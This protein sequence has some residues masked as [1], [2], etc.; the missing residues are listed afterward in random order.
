M[1]PITWD[2]LDPFVNAIRQVLENHD[3]YDERVLTA[4]EIKEMIEGP[5]ASIN[6]ALE[7]LIH[8][9]SIHSIEINGE[10]VYSL[11][12]FVRASGD[13]MVP[14]R[15]Q[16][17]LQLRSATTG[18]ELGEVRLTGDSEPESTGMTI[19]EV[20]RAAGGGVAV[21]T[22]LEHTSSAVCFGSV[23]RRNAKRSLW[24]RTVP[25][26]ATY[27]AAVW[28]DGA[29]LKMVLRGTYGELERTL[30]T[31]GAGAKTARALLSVFRRLM[32]LDRD[33]SPSAGAN[34]DVHDNTIVVPFDERV[35]CVREI[36]AE[37]DVELGSDKSI[38]A[39]LE[40]LNRH[41]YGVSRFKDKFMLEPAALDFVTKEILGSTH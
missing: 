2:V 41:S 20:A 25:N 11:P 12:R 35:V 24:E 23:R 21:F 29:D 5:R 38:D 17:T 3:A 26:L 30:P 10:L 16:E 15:G 22:V 36:A 39:G 13:G 4:A 34:L 37:F 40:F 19:Q 8:G 27:E 33:Y 18:A 31:R 9:N 1:R 7:R 14:L 28:L 6:G 32:P